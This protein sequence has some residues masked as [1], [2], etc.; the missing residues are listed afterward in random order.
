MIWTDTTRVR[1]ASKEQLWPSDLMD[2]EWKVPEPVFPRQANADLKPLPFTAYSKFAHLCRT[3]PIY[4]FGPNNFGNP[5]K[6]RASG[7]LSFVKLT[8]VMPS[9]AMAGMSAV[10][11]R[12][13]G[14]QCSG[15]VSYEKYR[16]NKTNP[17]HQRAS[18]R[19][20][21]PAGFGRCKD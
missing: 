7:R 10:S 1:H 5:R 13:A 17:D 11:Q 12:G 2:R 19:H 18:N 3:F 4:L 16:H 21:P 14:R 8:R 15:A 9:Q 6:W 20:G